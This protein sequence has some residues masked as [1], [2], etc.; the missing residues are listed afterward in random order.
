[1]FAYCYT[2][3]PY[4]KVEEVLNKPVEKKKKSKQL[5]TV[6]TMEEQV[7]LYTKMPINHNIGVG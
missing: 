4:Q 7:L 6:I 2:I 3:K 1:M 5:T